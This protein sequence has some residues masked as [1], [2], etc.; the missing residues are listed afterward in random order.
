MHHYNLHINLF[1]V[2]FHVIS[3]LK[4]E[5]ILQFCVWTNAIWL[6]AIKNIALLKTETCI[7]TIFTN[8]S[9]NASYTLMLSGVQKLATRHTVYCPISSHT[10]QTTSRI[11]RYTLVVYNAIQ[12]CTMENKLQSTAG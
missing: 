8:N 3:I 1:W 6:H 4:Y 9:H 12:I 5:V 10:M 7:E 2:L 11:N